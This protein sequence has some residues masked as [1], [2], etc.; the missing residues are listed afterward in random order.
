MANT[1]TLNNLDSRIMNREL[2]YQQDL[3]RERLDE[4]RQEEENLDDVRNEELK[5][6]LKESL[7]DIAM[8]QSKVLAIKDAVRVGLL[9]RQEVNDLR[10]EGFSFYT[11]LGASVVKDVLDVLTLSLL[12][13]V[14]NVFLSVVLF[15]FFFLQSSIFKRFFIKRWLWKY[16]PI[17]ILEF[18]PTNFFPSYTLA[19]IFLKLSVDKKIRELKEEHKKNEEKL[20]VIKKVRV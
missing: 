9:L 2:Q 12:G 10:F 13:I 7:E 6:A 15:I 1:I 16:I 8:K 11:V 20:K 19:T 4:E 18:F 3:H 17:V 14:T 5:D